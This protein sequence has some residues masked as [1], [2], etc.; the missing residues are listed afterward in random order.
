MGLWSVI[1]SPLAS[2]Q[3]PVRLSAKTKCAVAARLSLPPPI[4]GSTDRATGACRAG[5][6]SRDRPVGYLRGLGAP[7]LGAIQFRVTFL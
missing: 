5:G 4:Y 6:A 7:G 2:M 1:A 3:A